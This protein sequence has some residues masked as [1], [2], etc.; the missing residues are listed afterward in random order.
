MLNIMS[1]DKRINK[2]FSKYKRK[3]ESLQSAV[4]RSIKRKPEKIPAEK[5]ISGMKNSDKTG[6]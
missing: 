1:A 2:I 6:W 3:Q 5:R 4:S